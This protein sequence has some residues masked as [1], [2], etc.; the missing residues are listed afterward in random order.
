M[1]IQVHDELVFEVRKSKLD[2]AKE[3]I[4]L[5]ME[6]ALPEEYSSIVTLVVDVGIGKSW[7][8]AH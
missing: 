8:E 4:I 3:L 5:K 7:Y 2:F 6:K 1:I